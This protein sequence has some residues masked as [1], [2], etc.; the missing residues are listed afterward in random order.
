MRQQQD[1]QGKRTWQKEEIDGTYSQ[2]HTLHYADLDG[3]GVEELITGKR[4]YAHE[5]EPGDVQ[6]PVVYAYQFVTGDSKWKRTTLFRGQPAGNAPANPQERWAL[7][8]FPRG[9]VGTG[10]QVAAVDLDGDGDTDL[11]CPGKSGLYYLE[12][13]KVP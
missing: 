6:A 3:D 10:L 5:V 4:V 9:S 7:K 11:V 1:A 12:N 13:P 8:D 2:V